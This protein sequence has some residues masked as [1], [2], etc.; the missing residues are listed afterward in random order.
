MQFPVLWFGLALAALHCC[1][2]KQIA[3]WS[4]IKSATHHSYSLSYCGFSAAAVE[5]HVLNEMM[6]TKN[7]KKKATIQNPNSF[8]GWTCLCCKSPHTVVQAHCHCCYF[9]RCGLFSLVGVVQPQKPDWNWNWQN[10]DCSV[11]WR[12]VAALI[13]TWAAGSCSCFWLQNT[14]R[15]EFLPLSATLDKRVQVI[16]LYLHLL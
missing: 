1:D 2:E 9:Y 13:L 8:C 5:V 7:K 4:G 6:C 16:L 15:F 14:V 11:C 3:C 12:Q 10:E